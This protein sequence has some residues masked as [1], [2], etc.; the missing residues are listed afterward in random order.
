MA[1]VTGNP[2]DAALVQA[3]GDTLAVW[4]GP[5]K[6][7]RGWTNRVSPPGTR[8]FVQITPSGGTPHGT[9]GH[10]YTAPEDGGQG[11]AQVVRP[12]SRRVQ[13]DFVGPNAEEQART[14]S[15]LLQDIVGCD[16]LAPYGFAPI[17][18][19]EPQDLTSA[20]G[21]EQAEP[22]FML[23]VEVQANS[24]VTVPLDYF[25]NVNLHLHPQA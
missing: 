15:T 16:A 13:L 11:H 12:Q 22:R 10:A 25:N 8:Y 14:A 20:D 17:S 1:D 24:N 4:L 18:V 2:L 9:T 19:S 7:V 3:L 23:A 21:S 6:I 5:V